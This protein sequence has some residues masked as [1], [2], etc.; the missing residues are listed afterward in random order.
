MIRVVS[1]AHDWASFRALVEEYAASLGIDLSFQGFD[2]EVAD[3]PAHYG[4]PHGVAL[5]AGDVGCAGVRPLPDDGAC[6]L[7][8][9]YVRAAARGRGFGR[10]LAERAVAEARTLGY[11]TMRLDTLANMAAA[12]HV[13]HSLGFR[14]IDAYRANPLDDPRFFELTL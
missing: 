10:A 11:R 5:L 2:E 13:Y 1:T 14:E 7:K 6:E 12:I 8:R 9:M 4:P 3:L